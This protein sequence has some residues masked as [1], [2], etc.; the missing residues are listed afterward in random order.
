[1]PAAK[2]SDKVNAGILQNL[3][4]GD[5]SADAVHKICLGLDGTVDN[6]DSHED[7]EI[8]TW[9]SETSGDSYEA[10]SVFS[11]SCLVMASEENDVR[12]SLWFD[13]DT[14][15]LSQLSSTDGN[16]TIGLACDDS[17]T[18]SGILPSHGLAEEYFLS[19]SCRSA[20]PDFEDSTLMIKSLSDIGL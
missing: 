7:M 2:F 20:S 6:Q 12:E 4:K 1:M 16:R 11:D 13:S 18:N 17:F 3:V 14:T 10:A 15:L 9:R 8:E 19:V 5:N